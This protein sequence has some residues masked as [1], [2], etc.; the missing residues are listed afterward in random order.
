MGNGGR[1][2]CVTGTSWSV[3]G[4]GPDPVLEKEESRNKGKVDEKK[5]SVILELTLSSVSLEL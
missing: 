2:G 5:D 1:R 4:T 3:S